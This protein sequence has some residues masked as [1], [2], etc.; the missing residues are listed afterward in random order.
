MADMSTEILHSTLQS[1][2]LRGAFPAYFTQRVLV[3]ADMTV[4]AD[5]GAVAMTVSDVVI[6]PQTHT[7]SAPTNSLTKTPLTALNPAL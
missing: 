2:H 4:A 5:T 1:R 3:G 6:A 7:P